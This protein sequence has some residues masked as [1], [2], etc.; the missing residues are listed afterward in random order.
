MQPC[1]WSHRKSIFPTRRSL[2]QP[3]H[4]M[5]IN[6]AIDDSE[7]LKPNCP[8]SELLYHKLEEDLDHLRQVGGE[9]G[10]PT[11]SR[12]RIWIVYYKSEKD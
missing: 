11:T 2:K 9:F 1:Q 7:P 8:R 6:R 3:Y 12:R 4:R 5:E 10:S